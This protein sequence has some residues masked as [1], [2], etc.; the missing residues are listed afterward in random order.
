MIL[1]VYHWILYFSLS[2]E[3][4]I[5]QLKT[6]ERWWNTQV[7]HISVYYSIFQLSINFCH[8]QVIPPLGKYAHIIHYIVHTTM[9]AACGSAETTGHQGGRLWK[10]CPGSHLASSVNRCLWHA[11]TCHDMP[12][13]KWLVIT[14]ESKRWKLC[15]GQPTTHLAKLTCLGV[16]SSRLNRFTS[17]GGKGHLFVVHGQ[18]TCRAPESSR[19]YET[20]SMTYDLSLAF[21]QH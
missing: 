9:D 16:V 4:G 1:H 12:M 15:Q 8:H 21:W 20:C 6:T 2:T 14:R 19:I 7:Q 5:F 13:Y 3:H 17:V 10:A 11:M 18:L